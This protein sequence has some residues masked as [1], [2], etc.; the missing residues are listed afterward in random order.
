MKTTRR[1]SLLVLLA[2]LVAA[3]GLAR[4]AQAA[5]QQDPELQ[6]VL[7]NAL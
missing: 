7:S 3:I 1:S 6:V 4:P 2:T 5:P